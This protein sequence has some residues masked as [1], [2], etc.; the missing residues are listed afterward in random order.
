[1]LTAVEP[2]QSAVIRAYDER[3]QM[4]HSS[5]AVYDRAV[6]PP[7]GKGRDMVNDHIASHIAA[8]WRMAF[9]STNATATGTIHHFIW[10]GPESLE[11]QERRTGHS[12]P[13][14]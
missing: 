9:Y 5:Q 8:G 11:E 2:I 6:N 1:M 7:P 4:I 14:E 13:V 12:A 3:M 10:S